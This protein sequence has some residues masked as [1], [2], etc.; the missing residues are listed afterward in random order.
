[1]RRIFAAT[2]IVFVTAAAAVFSQTTPKV[3]SVIGLI[4]TIDANAQSATIKTD[5]GSSV[6]IK[7]DANTACLRIPAGEK[8]LA[9]AAPIQFAEIVAGDRVLAHGTRAENQFLAQR[10]VVMPKAEVAKKRAH[11]LEDWRLRGI[12]GI[13]REVNPQNGEINLELRS[14]GAGGRV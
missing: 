6:E 4:V 14:A 5:A 10:L 13:V 1:M 11:D 2:S 8:T 3:E 7:A 12:G 9:K